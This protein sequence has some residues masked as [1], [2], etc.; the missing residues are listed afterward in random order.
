MSKN[1]AN[2]EK[3]SGSLELTTST[4]KEISARLHN[5]MAKE[6]IEAIGKKCDE[7]GS[8]DEK[9]QEELNKKLDNILNNQSTIKDNTGWLKVIIG[10]ATLIFLIAALLLNFFNNQDHLKTHIQGAQG[11]QGYQG[12]QG[13]QGVQGVQGK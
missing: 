3:I 1:A 6:I 5:G 10:G 2:L 12:I 4:L 13:V 11:V 9:E 7:C 8:D